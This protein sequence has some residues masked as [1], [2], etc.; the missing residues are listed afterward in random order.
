VTAVFASRPSQPP[1]ARA[2]RRAAAIAAVLAL[3][4][5]ASAASAAG[6]TAEELSTARQLFEQGLVHEDRGEH[7]AALALYQRIAKI[8]VS[9]VLLYRTAS[10]HEKLGH[11]VEAIN[12]YALAAQ[13]AERKGQQDLATDAAAHREALERRAPRL[14]VEAPADAE[15]LAI[16]L[17]GKPINAALAGTPML[18]D[19]GVRKVVVRAANYASVFEATI[20]LAERDTKS[21]EARLGAKRPPIVAALPARLPPV[22]GAPRAAAP[23]PPEPS[24]APVFVAG[25]TT[26]ALGGAALVTGL[27]AHDKHA[28]YEEQNAAPTQGS[29]ADRTALRDDGRALAITSTVLTG[30]AIVAGGVTAYLWLRE[31]APDRPTAARRVA[32]VSPW[33]GGEGAGLVAWGSL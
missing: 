30:A 31:P 23:P 29:L 17:D 10:C 4:S 3:T 25:A 13:E 20:P 27:L 11:A 9:P 21:V 15:E 22:A 5:V 18:V 19:P 2:A 16:E 32:G 7:A 12:A 6:P 24:R 26:V 14:I 28:D 33:V 8:T 1:P